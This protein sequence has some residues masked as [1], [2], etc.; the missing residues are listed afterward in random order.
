M[1]RHIP[2]SAPFVPVTLIEGGWTGML[3]AVIH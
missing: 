1:K 2:T 3:I